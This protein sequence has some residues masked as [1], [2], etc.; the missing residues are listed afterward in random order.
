[1]S[2]YCKKCKK[3]HTADEMCSEIKNK[4]KIH[5]EWLVEAA[6]FTTVIGEET[7][8]TTQALDKV[9]NGINK[10]VGT[11]LEYEGTWQ[12]AR[13]I[14]VF[15]RMDL[16]RY[17]KLKAFS[18]PESAKQYLN[19]A[20]G[21]QLTN[22]RTNFNAM[23]QEVDWVLQQNGRIDSLLYKSE[24]YNQNMVGVDG[25]TITRFNGKTIS[26][27]T[28]KAAES[29]SGL[30]TNV[31][32][33]V[34]AL[35]KG[36]LKPNENV[37]GIEGTKKAL[38]NKLEKEIAYA[39]SIG[40]NETVKVLSEAKNNLKIVENGNTETIKKS[41]KRL[42]DK[43]ARGHANTT[44]TFQEVGGKMAQGAVVGAALSLTISTITTYVRYRSGDLTQKE[45]IANI[46]EETIKGAIVGAAMGGITIFLPAGV[47]GFASGI[48]I[49]I[50]L[51][52]ACTN[53][54][55][56]IYGKGAYGAILDA[57]GYI[58]G[59]TYNLKNYYQEIK[60]NND[61]TTANIND[62]KILQNNIT[63]NFSVFEQM[64]GS[65]IL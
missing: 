54:L 51:N 45:A 12:Y 33:I 22:L 40:D 59:M 44:P 10:L 8:I 11:K 26:R 6:N 47:I 21:K 9:A 36:N 46:S 39:M 42:M 61:I 43:T 13:D 34:D 17:S 60:K 25:K 24:L 19:N 20:T 16:E 37:F 32:G 65:S 58:F 7:L 31:Q 49:G 57:S 64:K 30:N 63:N 3:L 52:E 23:G 18:T 29:N 41:S 55:D 1:M 35:K 50:Y 62:A 14:Q 4:L 48:A 15:K 5:P 53:I 56:E 27:T 38:Q 2:W 28:V